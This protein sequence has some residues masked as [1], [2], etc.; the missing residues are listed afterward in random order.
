MF[1]VEDSGGAVGIIRRTPAL[2]LLCEPGRPEG[3]EGGAAILALQDSRFALAR[4]DDRFFDV[5]S[6][7]R[8]ADVSLALVTKDGRAGGVIAGVVTPEVL[9]AALE[10]QVERFAD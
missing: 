5:V 4:E 3:T 8:R 10:D 1:V 7:L 9:A 2:A 6:R